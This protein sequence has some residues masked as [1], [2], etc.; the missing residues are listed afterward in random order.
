MG[1]ERRKYTRFFAKDNAFA[2]LR[3][4]FKSVGKI[5]DISING[6]AFSYLSETVKTYSD[7]HLSQVDIFSSGS[8][9]HLSSVPCEIVYN[10]SEPNSG[11]YTGLL[12]FRCGLNF[13][14]PT[15]SQSEQLK[16]F[17]EH[18]KIETSSS[19][20]LTRKVK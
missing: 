18:H 19:Q 10:I 16:L 13:T 5:N 11:K 15:K 8:N 4:G 9:F 7:R 3:N 2:A 1:V 6:L 12:L 20:T 17:I 14:E